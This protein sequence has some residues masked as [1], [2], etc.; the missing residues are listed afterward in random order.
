MNVSDCLKIRI[1]FFM[2]QTNPNEFDCH[3][4]LPL[5]Y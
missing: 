4:I 3:S 5:S 2:E 1:V